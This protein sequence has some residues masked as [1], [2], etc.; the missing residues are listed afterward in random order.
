MNVRF[1]TFLIGLSVL[2]GASSTSAVIHKIDEWVKESADGKDESTVILFSDLFYDKAD[3]KRT[4]KQ[5]Q[6]IIDA[7][8]AHN[9]F[10]IAEDYYVVD[11]GNNILQSSHNAFVRY[12]EACFNDLKKKLP[13]FIIDA[14]PLC[15]LIDACKAQ[16]ITCSN[17]EFRQHLYDHHDVEPFKLKIKEEPLFNQITNAHKKMIAE[18]SRITMAD[19]ATTLTKINREVTEYSGREDKRGRLVNE[20]LK[21]TVNVTSACDYDSFIRLI[22]DAFEVAIGKLEKEHM[23]PAGIQQVA[24][25]MTTRYSTALFNDWMNAR[26]MR[27]VTTSDHKYIFLCVA[28]PTR[29]TYN[30][31]ISAGLKALGYRLKRSQGRNIKKYT[32]EEDVR[33]VIENQ[34]IDIAQY[35][36]LGYKMEEPNPVVQPKRLSYWRVFGAAAVA[37]T[38]SYLGYQWYKKWAFAVS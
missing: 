5:Q 4:D 18:R 6:D 31:N 25:T 19:V 28:Q 24:N 27:R 3:Q 1:T 33:N 9:A 29:G 7:A 13:E 36:D 22:R 8:K 17:V 20:V 35:F 23:N 12:E 30:K 37:I 15:G 16:Q 11:D 38:L 34:A 32:T 10:V 14:T 2:L 21:H 26:I